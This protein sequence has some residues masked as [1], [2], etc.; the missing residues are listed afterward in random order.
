MI[1]HKGGKYRALSFR[2]VVESYK[3]ITLYTL[4]ILEPRF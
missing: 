3:A 2:E 1:T 4:A